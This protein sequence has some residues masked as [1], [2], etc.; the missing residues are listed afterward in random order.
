MRKS[1][2]SAEDFCRVQGRDRERDSQSRPRGTRTMPMCYWG[3]WTGHA[4]RGTR[5]MPY[6]HRERERERASEREHKV[7]CSSEWC[8]EIV[9]TVTFE[10]QRQ[11][12]RERGRPKVD[13]SAGRRCLSLV[14]RIR[15]WQRD[16]RIC[17]PIPR[18]A[19]HQG[20]PCH[21][22]LGTVQ[23]LFSELSSSSVTV[24]SE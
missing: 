16:C 10:Q 22:T 7:Q 4:F 9:G 8:V 24:I 17:R 18:F 14:L 13:R 15:I 23:I 1:L 12:A 6:P 19:T 21:Q 3:C 2:I 11:R 20:Q 5:T